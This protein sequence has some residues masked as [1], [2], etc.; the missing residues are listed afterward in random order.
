MS[1]A[2]R[3]SWRS[4]IYVC[5]ALL[6]LVACWRQNLLFMQEA[7]VDLATGFVVFWPALLANHATTS[8]TV[9][10]FLL[11]VAAMIWMVVEARRLGVRFVWA[12][13][14]LSFPIAISVTFPLFLVA[15]ERALA[16]QHV[17]REASPHAGRR[18]ST[19]D[20]HGREDSHAQPVPGAE[21][22]LGIGDVI[23]LALIGV[24]IVGFAIWTLGQ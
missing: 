15:R 3:G 17:E 2:R 6:A 12:Y 5:L 1:M 10:I 13:V 21:L 14:L 4:I 23:G 7:D 19:G 20:F 9:D 16:S 24:P 11:C 18:P 22:G 8:I